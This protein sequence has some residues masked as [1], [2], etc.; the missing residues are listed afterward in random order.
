M[1]CEFHE[2]AIIQ[3]Y[4]YWLFEESKKADNK[5]FH[6][7]EQFNLGYAAGLDVCRAKFIKYFGGESQ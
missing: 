7:G 4:K 5:A 2:S 3:A 6:T 1:S